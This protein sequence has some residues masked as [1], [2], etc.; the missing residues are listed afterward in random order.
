[1]G[2]TITPPC[3][4]LFSGPGAWHAGPFSLAA[5]SPTIAPEPT[6]AYS[7]SPPGLWE[8][9][10]QSCRKKCVLVPSQEPQGQQVSVT[11]PIMGFVISVFAKR[12]NWSSLPVQLPPVSDT[13]L[14]SLNV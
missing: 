6:A 7:K 14:L 2:S 11:C 12:Q 1:M 13:V 8:D 4:Y 3:P 9:R 5:L 10:S